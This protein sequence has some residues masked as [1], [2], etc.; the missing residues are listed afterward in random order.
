MPSS[1]SAKMELLGFLTLELPLTG[2]VVGG[3]LGRSCCLRLLVCKMPV[4]AAPRWGSCDSGTGC[5]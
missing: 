1:C 5:L 3:T 4:T 2:V